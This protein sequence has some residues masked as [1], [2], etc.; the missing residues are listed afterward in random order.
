VAYNAAL[1]LHQVLDRIPESFRNK[2]DRVFVCDDHSHDSTYLV[3]LGYK[4]LKP[5]LPMEVIRNPRNL[6]YGGNQKLGYRLA[7]EHDLDIVVMLHGDGQY[8]PECLGDVVGP[9]ERGEA[10]AVMGSRM[11]VKGAARRGGMPLYKYVGN[12]IL[13]RF[14]NA[15]LGTSLTEFHSGYRA[16]SVAALKTIPF[17][18]NSDG[19]DFDTEI[20]IQLHAAGKRIKE[21]PIPTY[22]GDEICYVNGMRYA[23]DVCI[24]VMRYRLGKLGF[25]SEDNFVPSSPYA[26]KEDDHSSHRTILQWMGQMPPSKVLDLGCSAGELADRVSLSGH[27]VVG[28]DVVEHPGVRSRMQHFVQADLSD[29]IP[30]EVGGEFDVILAADLIEHVRDPLALLHQMKRRLV[31]GGVLITSVPNFAHWYPR[32]RVLSGTFDYDQRGILD[33]THL[34]FF[35]RR[36]FQRLA[37]AAGF[38]IVRKEVTGLPASM[39]ISNHRLR[40]TVG[41]VDRALVAMRPTLF[42]YQF[43]YELRPRIAQV[44]A[45][46]TLSDVG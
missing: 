41:T 2:I 16:Y 38:E 31:D 6:G 21:V 14:E 5:E 32:L 4:H 1:T 23:K 26:L 29:G 12:R 40:R 13:T 42:A 44:D 20:I 24:D 18:S 9:L 19:F 46:T 10:D 43:V 45:A 25:T 28:V 7:I 39:L 36:S 27:S 30:A 11:M 3:G 37:Q 17:E 15:M 8:A 34:R 22:Y 35:T 33:S